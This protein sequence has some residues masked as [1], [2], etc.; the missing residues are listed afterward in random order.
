[1]VKKNTHRK[2]Y[3]IKIL[4]LISLLKGIGYK[5]D[6]NLHANL[7]IKTFLIAEVSTNFP[8]FSRGTVI[9]SICFA[10]NFI[11]LPSASP[12]VATRR[13]REFSEIPKNLRD[14][15]MCFVGDNE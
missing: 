2:K 9:P 8:R 12:N 6:S 3:A 15:D 5:H 13:L 10:T 14:S 11:C 1:M 4:Q 7:K